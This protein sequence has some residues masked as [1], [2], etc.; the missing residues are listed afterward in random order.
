MGTRPSRYVILV[1]A[2]AALGGLLFGFDTA[3]ISGTTPFIQPYFN[4]SDIG[5]G[6]TVSSLLLG[7][8]AG[9][10]SAG[11]PGDVFGRKS[12][13]MVSAGLFFLSA[14][15][16]SLS[17]EIEIFIAFRIMGGLAVGSASILSP[18]YIAEVA[19]A[20]VRGRM[21][22]VNQLAI[23]IGIGLAFVTNALLVN[24]GENNWRWMLVVMGIPAMLFFF[25]LTIAPSSPRW[26]MQKGRR[27]KSL[28]VLL[29]LNN[30]ENA[31]K[32]LLNIE[33]SIYRTKEE[34]SYGELFSPGIRPVMWVGILLAVFSQITGINSIMYYAPVIF[35]SIG[36]SVDSAITQ[37]AFIGGVNLV[38]TLV[39]I[40]AID[41]LGR[42]RLLLLGV[43][44]MVLSL[45]VISLAFFLNRFEGY[46]ILVCMLA[47]IASF[48]IS[49]GP[50]TW[51]LISEIFPNRLRS[52]A[53]SVAVMALWLTNFLLILVFPVM[54]NRLGGGFSFLFFTAMSIL[55][56]LF[57]LFRIPE[58]KGKSLEEIEN[59]L[60]SK[61]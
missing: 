60:I 11:K 4:L 31:H 40:A 43:S 33:Q 9:V 17:R 39:A 6:W 48:A 2:V 30:E 32:E 26:L 35:K 50:V 3:V 38:F 14:V 13:L 29:R 59:L 19:P 8:I 47:Y 20:A 49:L 22:S 53:M 45:T 58:T 51:V 36:N 44:G 7:C 25:S 12:T 18:M 56:L 34:G 10:L 23:V 27:E 41:K 21:V 42:K 55:L 37:T 57:T 52:K 28:E 1:T 46:L 5:L 15:G 54:L 24:T 61:N 16:S